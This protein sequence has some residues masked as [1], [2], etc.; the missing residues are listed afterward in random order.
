MT[1]SQLQIM[2]SLQRPLAVRLSSSLESC[3]LEEGNVALQQASHVLLLTQTDFGYF[4]PPEEHL[5]WTQE[6]REVT[7]ITPEDPSSEICGEVS[8]LM[9]SCTHDLADITIQE[10]LGSHIGQRCC[11]LSRGTAQLAC[12]ESTTI[13]CVP[14]ACLVWLAAGVHAAWR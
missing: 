10:L 6:E 13:T 3:S 14:D 9:P 8:I 2:L 5:M 11:S 1:A 12:K 4:G 7:Y